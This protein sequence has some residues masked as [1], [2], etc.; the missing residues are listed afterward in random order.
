MKRYTI[1]CTE[2]QTKK[3]LYLG[4]PI[5]NCPIMFAPEG[6]PKYERQLRDGRWIAFPCPTA[7]QMMGWL[8]DKLQITTW[9]INYF[10]TAEKYGYTIIAR[11]VVI[12]QGRR[13]LTKDLYDSHNK[14]TLAAIDVVLDY[15]SNK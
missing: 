15:L 14:A 8:M 4:A 11:D 1:Y 7:E 9:H 13:A 12:E 3:A 6:I 5:D 10:P 2:E